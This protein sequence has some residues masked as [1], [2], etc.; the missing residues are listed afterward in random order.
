MRFGKMIY[1]YTIDGNSKVFRKGSSSNEQRMYCLK[2]LY[3][4]K[5]Y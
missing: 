1:L 3:N 4:E 2:R 5:K